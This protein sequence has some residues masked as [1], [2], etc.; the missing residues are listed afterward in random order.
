MD[1]HPIGMGDQVCASHSKMT[2]TTSPHGAAREGQLS[3]YSVEAGFERQACALLAGASN[4]R[5]HWKN[6]P[7]V[8]VLAFPPALPNCGGR[9]RRREHR[10]GSPGGTTRPP[11]QPRAAA[12]RVTPTVSSSCS[13]KYKLEAGGSGLPA[14]G[15][16]S[17]MQVICSFTARL[18]ARSMGQ[19]EWTLLLGWTTVCAVS[20]IL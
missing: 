12:L 10:P 7:S 11:S 3:K 1:C 18:A 5:R 13:E 4:G 2:I 8:V 6:L 9:G 20:N 14:G 17:S 16:S 19:P 15:S